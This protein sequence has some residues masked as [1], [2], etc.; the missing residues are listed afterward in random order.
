MKNLHR[1]TRL[2]IRCTPNEISSI[3]QI[4]LSLNLSTAD[5]IRGAV[6]IALADIPNR[7]K[8]DKKLAKAI[9]LIATRSPWTTS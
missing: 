4:A 2:Q 6:S 5:L 1:T 8:W 9:A 3:N 7:Y